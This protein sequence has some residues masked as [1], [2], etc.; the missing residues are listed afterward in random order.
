MYSFFH[1]V[2]PTS[3]HT[4]RDHWTLLHCENNFLTK[5]VYMCHVNLSGI[6]FR[7]C[8]I[9]QKVLN[10]ATYDGRALN[11]RVFIQRRR[12]FNLST[13]IFNLGSI[14]CQVGLRFIWS[15]L[16]RHIIIIWTPYSMKNLKPN[17]PATN[18]QFQFKAFANKKKLQL[19]KYMYMDTIPRHRKWRHTPKHKTHKLF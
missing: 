17:N 19:R 12:C 11:I 5:P 15:K 8:W 2:K 6:I 16:L 18:W 4:L 9:K 1:D 7:G 14:L 13:I 3:V 10:D